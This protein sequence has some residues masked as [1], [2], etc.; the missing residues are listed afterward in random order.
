V[1]ASINVVLSDGDFPEAQMSFEADRFSSF[2]DGDVHGSRKGMINVNFKD[3]QGEDDYINLFRLDLIGTSKERG[4]AHGALLAKEITDFGITALNTYIEQMVWG[5][6]DLDKYPK[7]IQKILKEVEKFGEKHEIS[8]KIFR[9]A[10]SYVWKKE[11]KYQPQYLI[12]EIDGI[13]EGICSVAKEGDK[14]DVENWKQTLRE[15][16]MLPE[17]IRMSCTAYGA[18]GEATQQSS[19]CQGGLLQLRALDFGGGPFANYT[20][21]QTHRQDPENPDHAFVS[22]SF[23]GMVG[24]ITGV[25]QNGVGVSE[26]VWMVSGQDKSMQP[27]KYDG[28]A[29]TFVLRDILQFSKNKEE[30]EA[31]MKEVKRTW[32]IWVGVGDGSSQELNLVGYKG[33]SANVYTDET[34]PTMNGQP[35][36]KDI[37]YVDKHPQPSRDGAN[38]T[39]PTALKHYYGAIDIP[40][41]SQVVKYHETGDLHWAAYDFKNQKMALAVG[42]INKDG[43]YMPVGGDDSCLWCA[44]NRPM[45]IFDLEQ[46]WQGL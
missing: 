7:E 17:L 29:D 19:E 33:D 34:M 14:C 13:A 22:V 20:V 39:L 11:L 32:A 5:A 25:A 10:M 9:K 3:A 18:W 44:Y 16:N 37:A 8:P 21:I 6:L 24:V 42:K 31:H 35:F 38:G 43:E 26:K 36:I 41:T 45:V 46:L 1:L 4:F 28:E 23:P 27:G 15:V 30:A 12:D 40:T 2:E